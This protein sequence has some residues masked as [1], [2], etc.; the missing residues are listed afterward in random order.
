MVRKITNREYRKMRRIY[1]VND[2]INTNGADKIPANE[3]LHSE[4]DL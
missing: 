4:V 1:G 3:R 2:E